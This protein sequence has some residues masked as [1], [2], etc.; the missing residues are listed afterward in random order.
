LPAG[1]DPDEVVARDPAEWERIVARARP[2]VIH[3]METLAQASDLEDSKVKSAIAAQVLPLIEEVAD[4]I[5]REDYRQRLARFLRIDER[6]LLETTRP[7]KNR[8]RARAISGSPAREAE[9]TYPAT[10]SALATND[11]LEAHCLS[12]LIRRPDMVF[13]IDRALQENGLS[14]LSLDDFQS[15]DHQVLFGLIGDSLVQLNAE[16]LMFVLNGLSMPLME[17]ADQLLKRT[18]KLDPNEE[19]VLDDVIRALLVLRQRRLHQQMD[20]LR[21]LM[22]EA[23]RGGDSGVGDYQKTMAEY[24]LARSRLDRAYGRYTVHVI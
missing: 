7:S 13:R 12:I 6:T 20:H 4:P 11:L 1:L 8:A 17:L 22:E 3:V 5:E 19:R 18:Q 10:K 9:K 24:V 16:P 2:I 14:R 15:A 23:Q 21:F